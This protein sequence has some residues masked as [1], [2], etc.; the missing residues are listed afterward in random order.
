MPTNDFEKQVQQKME[1]LMFT[2]S[3][4]VW[5]EVRKEIR[6]KKDR[7]RLLFW[8][9]LPLLAGGSLGVYSIY[10]LHNTPARLLAT[11][12][13]TTAPAT[14]KTATPAAA[15]TTHIYNTTPA[16]TINTAHVPA[17]TGTS[18]SH[19]PA[20]NQAVG[21]RHRQAGGTSPV[22][23]N[24]KGDAADLQTGEE[25]PSAGQGQS[26]TTAAPPTTALASALAPLRAAIIT[27]R[28]KNAFVVGITASPLVS[29]DEKSLAKLSPFKKKMEWVFTANS[30]ISGIA[31]GL[32]S[33]PQSTAAYD[34]Y[35]GSNA[36][37]SSPITGTGTGAVANPVSSSPSNI[38]PGLSLGLGASLRRHI[39]PRV[40]LEAGVLYSY[41][42]TSVLVGK[43]TDS[44]FASTGASAAYANYAY[45]SSTVSN[46]NYINR[47]HFIEIPLRIQQELGMRSPLS[48]QAGI[49]IG[50]LLASNALQYDAAKNLYYKDNGVF[51][52]TQLT[53]SAGMDIRLFRN[54]PVSLELGPRLQY[55]MTN[56]FKN[57]YY[58]SRH[59]LFA[60]LE[61]RILL[62]KK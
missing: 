58:G 5:Q 27:R 29:P 7:R 28:G 6:P 4:A 16:N 18:S 42:S 56:L 50:R 8:W 41:Y 11:Q 36:L 24:N 26:T 1:E 39:G 61:T 51:N 49:S 46:T 30:G 60:G 48:L 22:T 32:G 45:N 13:K 35:G 47:Y 33:L 53:F 62:R 40:S 15:N 17:A 20:S 44:G 31:S 43:K 9:L 3:E 23:A 25:L 12:Q 2:P 38:K 54:R 59:L 34:R 55:G 37:Q 52:K 14:A 57:S 21:G 10:H 19:T